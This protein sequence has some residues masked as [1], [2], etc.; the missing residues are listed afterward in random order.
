[1]DIGQAS[2]TSSQ[3]RQHSLVSADLRCAVHH[4][5]HNDL[6]ENSISQSDVLYNKKPV[7][8]VN[9]YGVVTFSGRCSCRFQSEL[10]YI[11]LHRNF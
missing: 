11:T 4:I 2:A 9:K 6:P 5:E 3:N 8:F 10:H 7:A 1:M